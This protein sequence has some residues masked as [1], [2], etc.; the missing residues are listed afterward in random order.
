MKEV[1]LVGLLTSLLVTIALY[2]MTIQH[3]DQNLSTSTTTITTTRIKNNHSHQQLRGIVI[4]EKKRIEYFICLDKSSNNAIENDD[5]CDCLD[6]SDETKT[7][8]CSNI[9]IKKE[10][11]QCK[12]DLIKIYPSRVNDG[13]CDCPDG[14]DEYGT[15]IHCSRHIEIGKLYSSF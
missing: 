7:S 14:S 2:V 9:Q 8:A 5:Y 3:L 6:G 12:K 1:I 4:E 15:N 10:L 11:F 13:V